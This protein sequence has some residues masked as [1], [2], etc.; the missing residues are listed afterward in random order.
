[1]LFGALF[2]LFPSLALYG[3]DTIAISQ[4]FLVVLE[5]LG[6]NCLYA[7]GRRRFTNVDK[8]RRVNAEMKAFRA[9]LS[10][11]Q[12]AGDKQKL[13]KLKRK[14]QQMQK[15]QAEMSMDNLKPTLLFAVP[16]IGVYYLVS[17]FLKNSILAV[18]PVP[19]QLF[20][21]GPSLEIPFFWWYFVCSFTFQ[22]I[23]TRLFGLS[24]D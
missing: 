12:K 8:M 9:E 22:G 10:T 5:A 13:E 18:G 16:L 24:M 7:L 4:T 3:A 19:F 17:S 15:M 6:V 1:M 21:Y 20:N 11:A 2:A 14:Q 23:V